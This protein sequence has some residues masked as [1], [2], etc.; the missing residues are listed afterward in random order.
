MVNRQKKKSPFIF[1]GAATAIIIGVLVALNSGKTDAGKKSPNR[2]TVSPTATLSAT[3][4]QSPTPT[5]AGSTNAKPNIFSVL[6]SFSVAA[7][8]N[9]AETSSPQRI[10][11]DSI[12]GQTGYSINGELGESEI[13]FDTFSSVI[14]KYGLKLNSSGSTTTSK[15]YEKSDLACTITINSSILEISCW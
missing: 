9:G 4:S 8:E 3:P 15:L 11:D 10:I 7:A 5:V 2:I 1:I 14:S 13:T 6:S 12:Q